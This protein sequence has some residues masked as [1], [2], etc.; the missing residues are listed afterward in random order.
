M[1]LLLHGEITSC[2]VASG[3]CLTSSSWDAII[4]SL[5]QVYSEQLMP[6]AT[7]ITH[8][9]AIIVGVWK[10][11]DSTTKT[12]VLVIAVLSLTTVMTTMP[13][14]NSCCSHRAAPILYQE[15]LNPSS[16][17]L[18]QICLY[19]LVEYT[20][21]WNG[22]TFLLLFFMTGTPDLAPCTLQPLEPVCQSMYV[23][24]SKASEQFSCDITLHKYDLDVDVVVDALYVKLFW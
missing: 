5:L 13:H 8:H 7:R 14:N 22:F 3:E 11:N 10:A 19:P 24:E 16:W 21:Q 15:P 18:F 1:K 20:S 23:C 2:S 4:R 9:T 12:Y 6:S 17:C